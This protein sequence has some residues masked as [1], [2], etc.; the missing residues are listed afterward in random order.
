MRSARN[1]FL[2]P[3]TVA[4][5]IVVATSAAAQTTKEPS[6]DARTEAWRSA[7]AAQ[8]MSAGHAQPQRAPWG[9]PPSRSWIESGGSDD[10]ATP[11]L[12]S[13]TFFGVTFDTSAAT[14]GVEGQANARCDFNGTRA[15]ENDVWFL[16]TAPLD[17]VAIVRTCSPFPPQLDTRV[18]V[19]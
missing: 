11:E 10:C 8:P 18:A 16:W 19:Y 5:W 14:T 13:G 4:A 17:G 6:A 15:I 1:G 7:L 2:S 9:P 3:V 12:L